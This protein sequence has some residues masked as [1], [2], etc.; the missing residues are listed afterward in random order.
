MISNVVLL[1][2][3]GHWRSRSQLEGETGARGWLDFRKANP[4][5]YGRT[6]DA[7]LLSLKDPEKDCLEPLHYARILAIKDGGIMLTGVEI[8]F[9][10]VKSKPTHTQQTWWCVVHHE[11]AYAALARHNPRSSSGFDVNDDDMTD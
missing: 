4:A 3:H 7:R 5:Y 9:R 8:T 1:R 6:W 11:E 10:A 2:R